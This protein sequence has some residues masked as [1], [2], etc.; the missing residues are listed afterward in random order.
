[1]DFAPK[2][3]CFVGLNGQ[4]KTNMLDAIYMLSFAKS[5]HTTQD[6]LNIMHNE[7]MAFVQGV[8]SDEDID[9]ETNTTI[10]CGLRK[11]IKKQFRRDKKDYKRL[12]DHIGL[13]HW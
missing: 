7:E 4:G 10:S 1:M 3:N 5:A 13:I 11:G 2:L 9:S 8:Y 6:S 12:I